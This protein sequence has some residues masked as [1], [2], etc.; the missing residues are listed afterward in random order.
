VHTIGI[1]A[2]L[3][4]EID[5]FM[6]GLE[7]SRSETVGSFVIHQ[8]EV[9]GRPVSL[10]IS[11]VGRKAAA[12]ATRA[13]IESCGP[14]LIVSTG[15]AGG[16]AEG[17]LT[18]TVVYGRD[19][20][21][22]AGGRETFGVPEGFALPTGGVWGG[23]LTSRRFISAVSHRRQLRDRFGAVAVD[24]E[25]FHVGR[26]AREAGIPVIAVRVISDDLSAELPVMGSVTT[27]DGRLDIRRAIP[28]FVRHP[29]KVIAFI[30][31]MAGLNAH[32]HT[33][34]VCL[35]RLVVSLTIEG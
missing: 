23:I 16:L 6:K 11:G 10:V 30:R 8:G 15:F 31:F 9:S 2:A 18:G 27:A 13:L 34:G 3:R 28:Y 32:A 22:D 12:N 20:V 24:M 33:L 29:G 25:S 26:V 4:Q 7:A 17:L 21:D 19:L 35:R 1:I 14:G 5:P